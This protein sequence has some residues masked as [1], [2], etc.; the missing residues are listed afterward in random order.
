MPSL[1]DE[2]RKPLYAAMSNA[3][4]VAELDAFDKTEVVSR[5]GSFRT[6]A[7]LL[8]QEEYAAVKTAIE[9]AASQSPMV[10]DMVD[11]LK[12]PG[13]EQGNGGGI[14]LG[15]SSVRAM[16]DQLCT[17]EVATKLK[18]HAERTVSTAAMLGLPTV[19][20]NDVHNARA[21]IAAGA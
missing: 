4:A 7:A 14:D 18:S 13:D 5:F 2:L 15:N 16:L 19:Y 17:I 21:E 11:F 20:E 12:L 10:A 6:L 9:Q 1:I 3:E 8:T